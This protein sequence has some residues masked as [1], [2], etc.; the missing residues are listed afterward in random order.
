M[1][2]W[3]QNLFGTRTAFFTFSVS[4]E[5]TYSLFNIN[6][7]LLNFSRKKKRKDREGSFKLI[8]KTAGYSFQH[9]NSKENEL[10]KS[11]TEAFQCV[12]R[13]SNLILHPLNVV[14]KNISQTRK[15]IRCRIS[16]HW[17]EVFQWLLGPGQYNACEY[18][19]S[20]LKCWTCFKV[21]TYP[22]VERIV[23]DFG[24]V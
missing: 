24:W 11:W 2:F 4:K 6:E 14:L 17:S 16:H 8:S 12:F 9:L 13:L 3:V 15:M 23:R 7:K 22:V 18:L 20:Y 19:I 10:I 5:I 1:P 21:H